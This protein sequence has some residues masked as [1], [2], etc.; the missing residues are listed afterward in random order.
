[1]GTFDDFKVGDR[2]YHVANGP[3]IVSEINECVCVTYDE[4]TPSGQPW[5]GKYD[6]PWFKIHPSSLIH[7]RERK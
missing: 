4:T 7:D 1:M 2:V 3:G 6:R 5:H